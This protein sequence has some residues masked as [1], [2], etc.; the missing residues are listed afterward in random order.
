M[1]CLLAL[2]VFALG[3]AGCAMAPSMPWLLFWRTWQGLGGGLLLSLS[4]ATVPLVF[5]QRLWARDMGPLSSMWGIATLIGP[6]VGGMFA[7]GGHWRWAFWAVLPVCA[8]LAVLLVT[9]IGAVGRDRG[10]RVQVPFGRIGLLVG[11]VLV[12]SAVSL[13]AS[14]LVQLAGVLAGLALVIVLARLDRHATQRFLPEGADRK[15]TRLNSSH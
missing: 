2:G 12:V 1:I 15:S 8:L 7:Q 10:A 6:A 13:S 9:Q 4:Y 5:D 3:T 14:V 11:S